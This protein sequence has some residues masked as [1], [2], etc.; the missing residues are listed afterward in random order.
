MFGLFQSKSEKQVK[1]LYKLHRELLSAARNALNKDTPFWWNYVFQTS[2]NIEETFVKLMNIKGEDYAENIL[3][4][5]MQEQS[6][7]FQQQE[8]IFE[9]LMLSGKMRLFGKIFLVSEMN[10]KMFLKKWSDEEQQKID[11]RIIKKSNFEKT[12]NK[13]RAQSGMNEEINI[14]NMVVVFATNL[15]DWAF[16]EILKKNNNKLLCDEDVT[17]LL[18]MSGRATMVGMYLSNITKNINLVSLVL[19]KVLELNISNCKLKDI[20]SHFNNFE[21]LYS[22]FRADKSALTKLDNLIIDTYNDLENCFVIQNKTVFDIR[23]NF[24][25]LIDFVK[26]IR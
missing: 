7:N 2:K 15:S 24:D 23:T 14:E 22:I 1:K 18:L 11:D 13:L 9:K 17:A 26:I 16:N 21:K 5:L 4:N 25:K 6:L 20:N 19:E 8:A 12:I 3:K 10:E